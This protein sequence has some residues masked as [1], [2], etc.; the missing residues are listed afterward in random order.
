MSMDDPSQYFKIFST[1]RSDT[2]R[3]R[4][5]AATKHRAPH[6]PLLLLSVIDLFAEGLITANLIELTPDLCETF[7]LYWS[8]VMP[9]D[10]R[11]NIALPFFHLKSDKFWHLVASPSKRAI[12]NAV[13]KSSSS[14][15]TVSQ[16][17]ELV[18]G[19][20]LDDELY[21]LLCHKESRNVLRAVLIE[22]YFVP[23]AQKALLE[24]GA[25]NLEAFDYSR[26]LL[27]QGKAKLDA[28]E[29][30]VKRAVRNQGFRRAIVTAYSHR[31]AMCSLRVITADGHTVVDAAHIVPWSITHN[32]NPN[33]GFALCQLCHWCFDEGM[34]SVSS[35]YLI[36]VSPQLS[37][38]RNNPNHLVTLEGTRIINPVED[39]F[40]PDIEALNWHHRKVF[41]KR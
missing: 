15:K 41:R 16:L 29:P 26:Q 11:G 24:Q 2:S 33:N 18:L 12:L 23:E 17:R 14:L 3:A 34:L 28:V 31:C 38:E 19:A 5:T 27:E 25:I 40:L 20:R 39:R 1:L 32:D 6:K 9:P 8:R 36:L 10:Q 35:A 37:F 21:S 22:E 4:W 13:L 7:T 30:E